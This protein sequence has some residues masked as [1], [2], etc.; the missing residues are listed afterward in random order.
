M[1]TLLCKLGWHKWRH[2]MFNDEFTGYADQPGKYCE[3]C[4]VS[5]H[6]G[7]LGG[8]RRVYNGYPTLQDDIEGRN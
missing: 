5:V 6:T 7:P 2:T 8:T 1:K 3:R 4:F